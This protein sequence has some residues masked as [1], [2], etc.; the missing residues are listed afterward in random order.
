MRRRAMV[1]LGA[2]LVFVGCDRTAQQTAPN[3]RAPIAIEAPEGIAKPPY[4]FGPGD[5]VFLDQ[6]QRGAFLYF[7]HEVHPETG[8][9][10]DRSSAEIVSVAGV[11]F[12]L[13]ALP[14]GVERG[15]VSRDEAQNRATLILRSL[16]AEPTNRHAG[17]F[18]HYLDGRTGGP[19]QEGYE[20]LVSTIDSALLFAGVITASSYFG[21]EVARMGDEILGAADW[22]AFFEAEPA[23]EFARG[24]VSLGWKPHDPQDPSGPGSVLPYSWLDSGD[25]HRL[26]TFLGV[27]AGEGRSLPPQTYYRLRRKLGFYEGVGEMVWFPWSGALFTAIFSHCWIDYAHMGPDNPSEF[28]VPRR[29]RV[30]WWEN[31]RRIAEMHRLEAIRNPH[32]FRTIGP[33]AWGLG[34]SDGPRGYHVA[35][36]HP[37]PLEMPG[38][39]PG[40]DY[41]PENSQ[42][43]WI[44]GTIAPYAAGSSILFLPQESLAALRHYRSLRDAQGD[45]LVWRDPAPEHRR[46]GFLDAYNLDEGWVASDYVAIDQGPLLLAIENARTG[47]IWRLFHEHPIVERGMRR[48]GLERR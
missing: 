39:I 47:L 8:M 44:D 46:Y 28:G 13:S 48:L 2:G 15:W 36:L 24:F 12:Q 37:D 7:W 27:C 42:D 20:V 35:H 14:I 40:V 17:L 6:V 9:V 41:P 26:V 45:P 31:S 19:S 32:G 30:D 38:A 16:L 25:E 10:R 23:A 33:N 29:V 5:A 18:Y 21:G 34:A 3:S 4:E 43:D 11:G 1:V 22:T